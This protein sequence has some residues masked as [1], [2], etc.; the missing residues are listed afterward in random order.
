MAVATDLYL[1]GIITT[2]MTTGILALLAPLSYR[3]A[4]KAEARQKQQQLNVD[5]KKE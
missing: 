3:L 5:E 1:I 2:V 4:A